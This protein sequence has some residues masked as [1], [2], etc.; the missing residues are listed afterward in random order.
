MKMAWLAFYPL[1]SNYFNFQGYLLI[2]HELNIGW[3]GDFSRCPYEYLEISTGSSSSQ[4]I[5]L[6]GPL[7]RYAADKSATDLCILTN[8]T[9][10]TINFATDW[11]NDALIPF[12]LNYKNNTRISNGKCPGKPLSFDEL[13]TLQTQNLL[14]SSKG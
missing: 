4:P 3:N 7:S 9:K 14:R 1:G 11:S 12:Q 5:K 6:C 10:I 8:S 13:A 2:I